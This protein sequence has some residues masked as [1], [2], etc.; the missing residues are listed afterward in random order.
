MNLSPD[1]EISNPIFICM[2]CLTVI[3]LVFLCYL[4]DLSSF[5]F[6]DDLVKS[7]GPKIIKIIAYC[8]CIFCL[9]PKVI[10]SF[11]NFLITLFNFFYCCILS[12]YFISSIEVS[13]N[14][15]KTYSSGRA[16][17]II[18]EM[19]ISH[20]N[21]CKTAAMTR[22]PEKYKVHNFTIY[23]TILGIEF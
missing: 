1:E 16:D 13:C 20:I 2:N 9:S 21:T 17:C 19:D 5:S 10:A 8:F 12:N 3:Y 22:V 4:Q 6:S 11:F 18:W 14:Q 15:Q 7:Y 23:L